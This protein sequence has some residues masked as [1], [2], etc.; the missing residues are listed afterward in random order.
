MSAL[1]SFGTMTPAKTC[2]KIQ[3]GASTDLAELG[4]FPD[5][6]HWRTHPQAVQYIAS[7]SVT[8]NAFR[9][10]VAGIAT[11]LTWWRLWVTRV[12]VNSREVSQQALEFAAPREQS[13]YAKSIP[14]RRFSRLTLGKNQSRAWNCKITELYMTWASHDHSGI[15]GLHAG[16]KEFFLVSS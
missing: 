16:R 13:V 5:H 7:D 8:A 3:E 2:Y 4:D 12:R 1:W 15:L 6:C 10:T 9:H 14:I 11:D